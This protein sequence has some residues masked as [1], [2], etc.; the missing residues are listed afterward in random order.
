MQQFWRSIYRIPY[1]NTRSSGTWYTWYVNKVKCCVLN[2]D[3][4]IYRKLSLSTCLLCTGVVLVEAF[5]GDNDPN[6]ERQSEFQRK[7]WVFVALSCISCVMNF[8]VA[9]LLHEERADPHQDMPLSFCSTLNPSS[10]FSCSISWFFCQTY[11]TAEFSDE[12]HGLFFFGRCHCTKGGINEIYVLHGYPFVVG[13][14]CRQDAGIRYDKYVDDFVSWVDKEERQFTGT[15][16]ICLWWRYQLCLVEFLRVCNRHALPY[17]CPR[18]VCL[19]G[20]CDHM[21]KVICKPRGD[22]D[23]W[24][25]LPP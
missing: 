2:N 20:I 18:P 3:K 17:T 12:L 24:R 8:N 16:Q 10:L 19:E 13:K 21:G 5:V 6:F 25:F 22:L 7:M 9:L 15:H 23:F 4:H 14:R 1:K 11:A